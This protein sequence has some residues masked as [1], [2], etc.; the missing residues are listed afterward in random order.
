MR[1]ERLYSNAMWHTDWHAMKDPRMKG[2]KLITYMDDASRCVTGAALFEEATPENAVLALR[3]AVGRFGVPATILAYDVY[4]LVGMG[5]GK[6]PADSRMQTVFELELRALD[7]ALIRSRPY[8]PQTNGKLKRF[9][10]SIEGEIWCYASLA[11]YVEYYNT[12]RL[13]WALDIDNYETP[14]LAFRNKAATDE[15]KRRNP[16][17]MEADINQHKGCI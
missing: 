9:Y 13:H 3:Q 11:D 5:G 17:W 7:I 15:I 12:D 14:M 10:Q 1:Y 6:R 2:L 4:C 16:K 8:S